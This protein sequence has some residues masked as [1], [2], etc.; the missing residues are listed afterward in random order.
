MT[1]TTV[2]FDAYGTL[3]DVHSAVERAGAPLGPL[4]G[5]VSQLW[6][7]KQLE[8][9]WITTLMGGFDDFWTLTERGLDFALARHGISDPALRSALLAAYRT[10]D[11][12]PDVAPALERLR[13][14]A[15]ATAIFTNGTRTMVDAAIAASGIGPLLDHVVT[16]EPVAAYKPV[17][18]V[19]DHA[20]RAAGAAVP[21]DIAFVSSN[22]WDV[23]GAAT[24]GFRTFWINR[25]GMPDEYPGRDPE[26]VLTDLSGLAA[27]LGA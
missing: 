1:A 5:P 21:G 6:R 8:Y 18:A 2:M 7:T 25:T 26:A 15:K 23:A 17:A 3:F 13:R 12:Y 20:L 27:A 4:A 10:L 11:A 14:A 9:S 24:F 16:V 19:Y 22:R